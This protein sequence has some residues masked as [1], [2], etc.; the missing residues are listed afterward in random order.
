MKAQVSF[1]SH[2]QYLPQ[3]LSAQIAPEIT[4][5]V[6]IGKAKS[7]TLYENSSIRFGLGKDFSFP[8]TLKRYKIDNAKLMEKAP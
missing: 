7:T 3:A 8:L 5:N 1:G 6:Q 4:A 2:P